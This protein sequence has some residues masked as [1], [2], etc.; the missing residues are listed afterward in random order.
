VGLNGGGCTIEL[1]EEVL[2]V[3]GI[4]LESDA[5]NRVTLDGLCFLH[6]SRARSLH[7]C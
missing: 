5:W 6:D 1:D 7:F 4:R 2:I 3:S